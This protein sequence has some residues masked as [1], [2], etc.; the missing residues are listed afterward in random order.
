MCAGQ[1]ADKV[2]GPADW[3]PMGLHA[4]PRDGLASMLGAWRQQ[5][6]ASWRPAL[7]VSGPGGEPCRVGEGR[8]P[9]MTQER[10][11]GQMQPRGR[12]TLSHK[13][14][15]SMTPVPYNLGPHSFPLRA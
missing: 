11:A 8:R 5:R 2:Q 10:P 13:P 9:Q 6:G 12:L 14:R 1:Q 15:A 7:E 3:A 4:G